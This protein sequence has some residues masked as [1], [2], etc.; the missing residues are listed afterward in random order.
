MKTRKFTDLTI[1]E[2]DPDTGADYDP[3]ADSYGEIAYL[4][5]SSAIIY[6]IAWID[7]Y[8]TDRDLDLDCDYLID[9]A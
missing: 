4:P 1:F 9:C 6:G 5:D 8:D 3:A 7:P 2:N